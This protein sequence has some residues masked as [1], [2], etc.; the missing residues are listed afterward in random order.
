MTTWG[1][2]RELAAVYAMPEHK[3]TLGMKCQFC[4]ELKPL[5]ELELDTELGLG[6]CSECKAR[7]YEY[8]NERLAA[9]DPE[10]QAALDKLL[11]DREHAT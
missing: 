7:L 10:L 1:A 11:A 9:G 2:P 6:T 8:L 5:D 3:D 4:E